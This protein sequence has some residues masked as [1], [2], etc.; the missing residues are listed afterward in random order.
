MTDS[1]SQLPSFK[2]FQD[3][4]GVEAVVKSQNECLS[5]NRVRGYVYKGP[6]CGGPDELDLDSQLCPWCIA[7][8]SAAELFGIEFS[9]PDGVGSYGSWEQVSPEV[10]DEV[11]KRTPCFVSWQQN[12]WWTHCN[13]AAVFID[14][15]GKEELLK[16]GS[17]CVENIK[18]SYQ[19]ID[20]DNWDAAFNAMQRDGSVIAYVFQCRH[21]GVLGGYW[22]CM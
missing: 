15:A 18:N 11:S 17:E 3:P 21:C 13:D 12:E 10:V 8:G 14:Y 19:P 16:Y 6:Y 7:D 5:C 4:V 1:S 20:E 22:D 9:D 2:Y